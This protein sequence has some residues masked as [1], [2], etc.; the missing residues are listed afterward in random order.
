MINDQETRSKGNVMKSMDHEN[1]V[2]VWQI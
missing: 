1:Y 2:L